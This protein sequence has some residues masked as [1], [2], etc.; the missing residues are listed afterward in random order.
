MGYFS[1]GTET[2]IY[3]NQYCEN[4]IHVGDEDGIEG[5]AVWDAHTMDPRGSKRVLNLLIPVDRDGNNLQCAMFVPRP[6]TPESPYKTQGKAKAGISL[7]PGKKQV[8]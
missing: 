6:E 2:E 1:N 7:P 4:C 8:Q 3:F 5:C